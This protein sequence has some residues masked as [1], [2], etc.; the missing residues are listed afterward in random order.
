MFQS[1]LVRRYKY[2]WHKNTFYVDIGV[3]A[4]LQ[5]G[6]SSFFI[7]IN[8]MPDNFLSFHRRLFSMEHETSLVL[9]PLW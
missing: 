2:T 1:M 6:F 5:L 8:E 9:S 4:D 7:L 3:L